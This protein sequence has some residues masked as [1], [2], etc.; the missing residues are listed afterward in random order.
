MYKYGPFDIPVPWLAG[1][2]AVVPSS[3]PLS[4]PCTLDVEESITNE[5]NYMSYTKWVYQIFVTQLPI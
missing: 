1:L 2:M 4:D 3:V 5:Y